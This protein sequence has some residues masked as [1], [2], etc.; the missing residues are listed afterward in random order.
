[1][2]ISNAYATIKG[3]EAMRPLKKKHAHSFNFS[4]DIKGESVS[5]SVPL[6]LVAMSWP[7]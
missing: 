2:A 7:I 6:A 4:G 1:M 5:L 3:F